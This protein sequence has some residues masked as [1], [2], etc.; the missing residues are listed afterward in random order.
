MCVNVQDKEYKKR[1]SPDDKCPVTARNRYDHYS[2]L[3]PFYLYA[4]GSNLL[5]V[6]SFKEVDQV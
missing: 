3:V 5:R 4:E 2:N 1:F 6:L